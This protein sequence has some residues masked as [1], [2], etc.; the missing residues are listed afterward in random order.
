ME[1]ETILRSNLFVFFV[2][3]FFY[4]LLQGCSQ[5]IIAP[6]DD[7]SSPSYSA[8]PL[9]YEVQSS[10]TL[11]G[12]A[13][14][15][16]FDY[17]EL[18]LANQI[19]EPYTIYPGD[20]LLFNK[21]NPALKGRLVS[22]ASSNTPSTSGSEKGKSDP[23]RGVQPK[24]KATAFP[25]TDGRVEKWLWPTDG[26]VIRGFSSDLHKGVDIGGKSGDVIVSSADGKVVYAG[27]GISGFGKLL[28][29]KHSESYLSAYGHNAELLVNENALVS[30]G[31]K[32]AT[33]GSSGTDRVKLHFEIRYEGK[34]M[35]PLK[36]LS[37]R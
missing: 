20:V 27:T 25:Q 17:R 23:P 16:G 13:F 26:E 6:V 36:Y 34:P 22:S 21:V 1:T 10:D 5:N 8:I 29:V 11:Y 7:R 31:Q 35:D 18:A 15:Y 28:I 32:I 14:R 33:K 37:K 9:H 3:S 2:L 4:F 30:A 24:P 19:A 12:I